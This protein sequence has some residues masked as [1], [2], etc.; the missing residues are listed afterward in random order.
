MQRNLVG[1]DVGSGSVRAV[2]LRRSRRGVPAVRRQGSVALPPGAVEAGVVRD[3]GAVTAALKQLWSEQKLSSRLVR[4][5][6]GSG[7]VMV[8]QLDLDWM[9]DQ[10]LRR[11]LRYQV[12]DLLPVPVDDAN[13]DHVLLGERE[14]TDEKGTP[15]RLARILLVATAR[16]AVDGVVRCAQAAGLRPVAADLSAFASMRT[17][18]VRDSPDVRPEA[19]VDIGADT[20]TVTVHVGGRPHFVRVSTG[21]GGELLTRTL[22]EQVGL[23]RDDAERLKRTPGSLTALGERPMTKAEEV[24]GEATRRLLAEIRT[25]LDFHAAHEPATAPHRLVLTGG[26]SLLPGLLPYCEA[27]L[28]LPVRLLAS[29]A[30]DPGGR[31]ASRVPRVDMAVPFGLCLGTA[32]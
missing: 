32:A 9:P 30:A 21:T 14:V 2:E 27:S 4:V 19:V 22:M 18:L 31:S 23:D 17:A 6:V 1:L 12:A 28:G 8:R 5:G 7:S 25:S 15:R 3:A 20:V 29:G 10:D 11:S 24:L 16:E 13:L 26:G